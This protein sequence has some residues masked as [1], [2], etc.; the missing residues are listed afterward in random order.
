MTHMRDSTK[1]LLQ[2]PFF[3]KRNCFRL[4]TMGPN[5]NLSQCFHF[6]YLR[7]PR[8]NLLKDRARARGGGRGG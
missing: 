6:I 8:R 7:D 2:R 4:P 1:D 5:L 3:I